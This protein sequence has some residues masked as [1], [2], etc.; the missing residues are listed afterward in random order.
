MSFSPDF[1]H[2]ETFLSQLSLSDTNCQFV[3]IETRE[4]KSRKIKLIK[5]CEQIDSLTNL[6]LESD[7]LGRIFLVSETERSQSVMGEQCDSKIMLLNLSIKKL[8]TF[9]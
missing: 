8:M 9:F 7:P 6:L 4:R 3:K 1:Y 2:F 5:P